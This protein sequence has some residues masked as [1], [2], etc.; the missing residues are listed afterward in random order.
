MRDLTLGDPANPDLTARYAKIQMRILWT[1]G[2]EIYRIAARGVRLR[3]ETPAAAA[4]GYLCENHGAPFR[5]PDL[6]PIGTFGLA[7]A[8]DFQAPAMAIKPG[9]ILSAP[10]GISHGVENTGNAGLV[11]ASISAG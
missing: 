7:N 8:R 3:V 10:A 9:T 4:R 6:G 1:G 2:V 5:L 11:F